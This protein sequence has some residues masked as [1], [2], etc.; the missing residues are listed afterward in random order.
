MADDELDLE[1]I[2]PDDYD[3]PAV[4]KLIRDLRAAAKRNRKDSE[5]GQAA[6]RELAF[7]KAGVDTDS[8]AGRMFAKAYEGDLKDIEAIK[9]GWSEIAPP[10]PPPVD[11]TPPEEPPAQGTP[12]DETPPAD[13][14]SEARRA[15]AG[16]GGV[17]GGAP[18][19]TRDE[20]L[21]R[22]TVM[23][24]TRNYEDA[25]GEFLHGLAVGA[26]DGSIPALTKDG[27]RPR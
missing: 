24:R 11:E 9:V 22:A 19:N 6:V 1:A 2:D 4:H 14:G 18:V 23:M 15:L 26:N 20:L 17:A 12:A 7:R 27:T 16:E 5:E 8:P 10:P 13:T 25:A 3:D 21:E